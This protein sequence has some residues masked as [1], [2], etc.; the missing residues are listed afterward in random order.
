[1]VRYT[2]TEVCTHLSIKERTLRSWI[3]KIEQRT[4]FQF[5]RKINMSNPRYLYGKPVPQI[6]LDDGDV[7]LLEKL[8]TAR[9]EG[10]NLSEMIDR[11]FLLHEDYEQK[12]PLEQRG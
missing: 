2:V 5:N 8:C 11:L 12:Y 3:Q 7:Q 1:M 9:M 6:L 10:A 4:A